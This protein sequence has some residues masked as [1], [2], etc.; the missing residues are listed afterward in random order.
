MDDRK[1][2]LRDKIQIVLL[3]SLICLIAIA[4]I[5]P[6]LYWLLQ[7][8]YNLISISDFAWEFGLP[9]TIAIAVYLWKLRLRYFLLQHNNDRTP[10]L[11]A[12]LCI[13][14][15]AVPAGVTVN[16]LSKASYKLISVDN[17][18][19]IVQADNQRYYDIKKYYVDTTYTLTY[20]DVHTSG[21][22]NSQLNFN[23]YVV[24]PLIVNAGD[25]TELPT[26]WYTT[27][28]HRDISNSISEEQK[29]A[30]YQEFIEESYGWWKRRDFYNAV[31]FKNLPLSDD[32]KG[33][34]AALS[35]NSVTIDK[36]YIF[37]EPQDEP[38][39]S[40]I[41]NQLNW[42]FYSF[43]IS[44]LVLSIISLLLKFSAL[45]FYEYVN[46]MPVRDEDFDSF[47]RYAIPTGDHF[48]TSIILD[49][50][51]AYFILMVIAGVSF[52]SPNTL[53]LINFGAQSRYEIATGQYWRLLSS[54]FIHAGIMHLAG[55]I[56]GLVMAGNILERVVGRKGFFIAYIVCGVLASVSSLAFSH[57]M[58]SVGASGAVFGLY[59]IIIALLLTKSF[60]ASDNPILWMFVAVYAGVNL[61][62]G[63]LIPGIDNAA[64]IGGLLGGMLVGLVT[65]FFDLLPE[66][67]ADDGFEESVHNE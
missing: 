4:T 60:R 48:I 45:E 66:K 31:Y 34:Q 49:L 61:I 32:L 23:L 25:T 42:I 43:V 59:G 39:T 2:Q 15:L 11:I 30:K 50:N 9:L 14:S 52:A 3:P 37:L 7:V 5:Y 6:L 18:E 46:G 20:V 26:R 64:H 13:A 16:Y 35:T 44:L 41:G 53:E 10:F 21:K 62:F 58:V 65:Y 28:Y 38:F 19:R 33:Y 56:V 51:L 55:N 67:E 63:F 8:R 57:T 54:T 36:N 22:Y 1:P 40:R 29:E 24:A 17:P 12:I 27:K 47:V